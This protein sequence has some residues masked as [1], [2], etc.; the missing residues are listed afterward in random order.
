MKELTA[1]NVE[2]KK[3]AGNHCSPGRPGTEASQKCSQ[4]EVCIDE[5]VAAETPR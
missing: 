5:V 2:Q 1:N 3:G 4:G